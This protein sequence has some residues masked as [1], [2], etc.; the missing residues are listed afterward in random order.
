MLRT[1]LSAKL[2]LQKPLF[3]DSVMGFMSNIFCFSTKFV[4][5]WKTKRY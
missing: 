2:Y 1:I 4:P 3:I 5:E